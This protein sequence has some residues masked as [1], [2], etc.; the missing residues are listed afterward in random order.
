MEE[1]MGAVLE[2]GGSVREQCGFENKRLPSAVLGVSSM[3]GPPC[4]GDKK[5][6]LQ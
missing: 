3:L 2:R 5:S 6:Q 1:R 4:P